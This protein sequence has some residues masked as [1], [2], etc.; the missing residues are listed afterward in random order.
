MLKPLLRAFGW[1]ARCGEM[2]QPSRASSACCVLGGCCGGSSCHPSPCLWLF[3]SGVVILAWDQG[4]CGLLRWK[5]RGTEGKRSEPQL[6][7]P[8]PRIPLLEEVAVTGRAAL[9]AGVG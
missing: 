9:G 7:H 8:P 1:G 6:A 3:G 5:E 2:Q 4:A